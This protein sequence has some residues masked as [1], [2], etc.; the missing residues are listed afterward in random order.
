[1]IQNAL[2]FVN[3]PIVVR[4]E[5]PNTKKVI[6]NVTE[7]KSGKT[8]SVEVY[9]KSDNF[10]Y[11]ISYL[12]SS[13]YDNLE[14]N[15]QTF[16][17]LL[18]NQILDLTIRI[19]YERTIGKLYETYYIK[20][21]R[22]GFADDR[23]NIYK[24][25]DFDLSITDKIPIWAGK[26]IIYSRTIDNFSSVIVQ[27]PAD[28]SKLERMPTLGCNSI[29]IVFL[30]HLGGYSS[31]LFEDFDIR[32]KSDKTDLINDKFSTYIKKYKTTGNKVDYSISVKSKV[33]KKWQ[34]IMHSLAISPV[35]FV[36][37]LPALQ[38]LGNI[39]GQKR[40]IN[41]GQNYTIPISKQ[42]NEFNFTFDIPVANENKKTW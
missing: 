21:I 41:N 17:V 37:D 36:Y 13:F 23:I 18:Q 22:G 6:I 35:V 34:P 30:N 1:M 16:G 12:L 39:S 25:S 5:E 40:I 20:T 10:E 29:Y 24:T 38:G 8:A 31:W 28:E 32:R 26:Q 14:Q 7:S 27:T 2:Y 33:D 11:D 3:N 9:P 42:V 19:T 15:N 4:R